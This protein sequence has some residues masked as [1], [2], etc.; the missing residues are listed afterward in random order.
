MKKVDAAD[1][2]EAIVAA[3][4]AIRV[5]AR[6]RTN[7]AEASGTTGEAERG[8]MPAHPDEQEILSG[9]LIWLRRLATCQ[10]LP[11]MS[12]MAAESLARTVERRVQGPALRAVAGGRTRSTRGER[13][14]SL[15]R[16]VR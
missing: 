5:A 10:S 7:R 13:R 2:V 15:A 3:A 14:G 1:W 16:A 12:R 4:P 8:T 9:A 6:K 11:Q